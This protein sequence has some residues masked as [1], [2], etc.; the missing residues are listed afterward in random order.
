M[1]ASDTDTETTT[2]FIAFETA[3]LPSA[4]KRSLR[5]TAGSPLRGSVR[6]ILPLNRWHQSRSSA[7]APFWQGSISRTVNAIQCNCKNFRK[8]P[9]QENRRP[10][11]RPTCQPNKTQP[12]SDRSLRA[13]CSGTGTESPC[14]E[15]ALSRRSDSRRK[16]ACTEVVQA[17]ARGCEDVRGACFSCCGVPG[18]SCWWFPS[19]WC[20][21]GS[22]GPSVACW[23]RPP[24]RP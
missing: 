8:P 4:I 11:V 2:P 9:W 6:G 19:A 13:A 18:R 24:R 5:K 23:Q 22:R 12:V 14:L 7:P 15:Q 1:I 10:P 3:R 17:I 20:T 16:K 21:R